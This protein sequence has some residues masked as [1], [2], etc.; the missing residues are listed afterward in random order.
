MKRPEQRPSRSLPEL[1]EAVRLATRRRDVSALSILYDATFGADLRPRPLSGAGDE[2]RLVACAWFEAWDDAMMR[3]VLADDGDEG[4]LRLVMLPRRDGFPMGLLLLNAIWLHRSGSERIAGEEPGEDSLL[5]TGDEPFVAQARRLGRLLLRTNASHPLDYAAVAR[6]LDPRLLPALLLWFLGGYLIDPL[7]TIDPKIADHRARAVEGFISVHSDRKIALPPSTIFGVSSFSANAFVT[8]PK[9]FL[10]TLSEKIMAPTLNRYR[11]KSPGE[12]RRR[13]VRPTRSAPGSDGTEAILLSGWHENSAVYRCMNPVLKGMISTGVRGIQVTP[14][15]EPD[16]DALPAMWRQI[17]LDV[18]MLD[19]IPDLARTADRVRGMKLDFLM[20][21]EVGLVNTRW[22][23]TQRL[24]RVQA[25]GYGHPVTT[26]SSAVD[27]FV[28]GADIET[29]PRH[30]SERLVLLPGL[31][32]SS[33]VPPAPSRSRQRPVGGA[34]T[35]LVTFATHAKLNL[36]LL[37]TWNA[38]LRQAGTDSKLLIAPG[39]DGT[40]LRAMMAE[41]A[42]HL[43]DG[44]AE[45]LPR[46][47]RQDCVDLLNECDIYLDSFPFG[48]YNTVVEALASGCIV[49]TREGRRSPGRFAAAVLR[50][51]G[52]PEW[53]IAKSPQDYIDAVVR[54]VGDVVLRQ[55]LRAMLTREHVAAAVCGD[56]MAQHFDA[57]VKWMRSQGPGRPGPPMLLQAG[58]QPRPVEFPSR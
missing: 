47:S 25:A 3:L 14:N 33:E 28:G 29:D 37:Q 4:L 34:E 44:A 52:L 22:L 13:R 7:V 42:P 2:R 41:L 56:D 51:V 48:G 16:R 8:D 12:K 43:V 23:A 15:A 58:D 11:L 49:V 31:G 27:Y 36:P 6:S 45:L 50:K 5:R 32:V 1:T 26:G 53:L 57:A 19:T 20:Y 9:L 18:A 35:L 38:A 21:P 30:F 40:D 39:L 24:A 46:M 10:Q 54:L 55:D 17:R